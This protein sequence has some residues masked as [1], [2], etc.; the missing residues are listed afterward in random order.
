[1][2]FYA[3]ISQWTLSEVGIDFK[4]M[5]SSMQFRGHHKGRDW[6]KLLWMGVVGCKLYPRYA[7][8]Y[9]QREKKGPNVL[10]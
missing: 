3:N 2:I 8:T 10:R 5:F 7:Q 1:M 4:V 9:H 6:G